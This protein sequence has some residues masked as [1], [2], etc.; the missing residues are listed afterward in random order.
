MASSMALPSFLSFSSTLSLNDSSYPPLVFT[1][2]TTILIPQPLTNVN[3][4]SPHLKF[5]DMTCH[6]GCLILD[7]VVYFISKVRLAT[8]KVATACFPPLVIGNQ[9][10]GCL[11]A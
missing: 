7:N 2:N 3:S 8:K 6:V 10:H 4:V 9:N 5:M 11:S 1:V